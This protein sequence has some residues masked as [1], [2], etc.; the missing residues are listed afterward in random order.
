MLGTPAY[1][2]P[3][4]LNG[5]TV[6]PRSDLFSAGVVLYQLLTGERPFTGTHV[7]T[8]IHKIL[9]HTPPDPST[10]AA[11]V[12]AAFDAVVRTAIAKSPDDRYQTGA[13]FAGAL[14]FAA[15]GE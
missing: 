4:Q 6:D 5:S 2:S 11:G 15:R 7:A 13:E 3:E 12:P 10:L 14:K 9:Q 8:I 1:M